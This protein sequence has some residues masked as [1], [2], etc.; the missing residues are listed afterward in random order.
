[1]SAVGKSFGERLKII[2]EKIERSRPAG[3]VNEIKILAVSKGQDLKKIEDAYKNFDHK[4]FGEN[5]AQE[6]LE[7]QKILSAA[8]IEW[9]FIGHL[10]TNK[11]KSVI[12]AFDL[13]HSV[14]RLDLIKEIDKRAKQ[15]QK[16]LIEVNIAD[17]DS[18]SGIARDKLFDLIDQAQAFS[19]VKIE[20]LMCMPPLNGNEK[21]TRKYFAET[22]DL[23]QKLNLTTLSMGTSEDFQW[24]VA[25]G[26]TILR[27]GT[28]LFG[29]RS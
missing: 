22:R 9:H 27:L 28:I 1:M 17:E 8:D 4:L 19:R 25:E 29:A 21:Q 16:V 18:K 7:K 26:A 13:I 23:A 24:A 20:G 12:G 3:S 2:Q 6:A 10:Q 5:Y 11:V 15:N 14:D